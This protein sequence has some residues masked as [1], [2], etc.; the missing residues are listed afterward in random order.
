MKTPEQIAEINLA[1]GAASDAEWGR[2]LWDWLREM[3]PDAGCILEFDTLDLMRLAEKH[4]RARRVKYDPHRHG[5]IC[6]AYPGNEIWWWGDYL[7]PNSVNQPNPAAKERDAEMNR[8]VKAEA[9]RDHWRTEY[10][11]LELAGNELVKQ[12]DEFKA[13][14]DKAISQLKTES[15]HRLECQAIIYELKAALKFVADECDWELC[16]DGGDDRIGP[17]CRLALDYSNS[18]NQAPINDHISHMGNEK[19]KEGK[20]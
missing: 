12:R 20:V 6:D 11:T 7:I 10:K 9:D 1:A 5:E 4:G 8:A 15:A 19:E 14:L 13:E 18:L 2:V 17:A 16:G 3:L